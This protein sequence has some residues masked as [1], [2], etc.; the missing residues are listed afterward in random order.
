LIYLRHRFRNIHLPVDN[1]VD[2]VV[3][4]PASANLFKALA[5]LITI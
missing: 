3:D 2:N 5:P 1:V 4:G